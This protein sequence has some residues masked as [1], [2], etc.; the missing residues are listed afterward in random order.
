MRLSSTFVLV[1]LVATTMNI[2]GDGVR[3]QQEQ[4]RR[5]RQQDRQEPIMSAE[6]EE[7][8]KL[9]N[10]MMEDARRAVEWVREEA[11]RDGVQQL[12]RR[13]SSRWLYLGQDD[14]ECEENKDYEA[15]VMADMEAVRASMRLWFH[16]VVTTKRRQCV[17]LGLGQKDDRHRRGN[18]HCGEEDRAVGCV[19][20]AAWKHRIEEMRREREFM[21]EWGGPFAIFKITKIPTTP[22]PQPASSSSSSVI[23][24][25][26][27][28][29]APSF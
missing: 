10:L 14:L 18:G 25:R 9:N 23:V 17:L 24:G 2:A 21:K 28:R 4:R 5:R 3:G 29:S 6:E 8:Q 11:E 7:E 22:Q 27:E 1:V 16:H 26:D 13:N 15:K 12:Q 19:G 20:V